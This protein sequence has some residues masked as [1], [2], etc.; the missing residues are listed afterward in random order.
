LLQFIQKI[1]NVPL[2]YTK[3]DLHKFRDIA[4]HDYQ[5]L[6]PI[7]EEYIRLADRADTNI[8]FSEKNIRQAI[9]DERMREADTRKRRAAAPDQMHLF[10]LLRDKRLFPSNS[11][12]SDFAGRIFPDMV[13]RRFDKMSRGDIAARVIEYLETLNPRTRQKLEGSMREAIKSGVVKSSDRKSFFSRWERII[14][15]TEL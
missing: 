5:S 2:G 9:I 8:V 6:T 11:D 14:K 12:L 1:L 10:D 15:G 7:I 13:R 4:W 3:Y